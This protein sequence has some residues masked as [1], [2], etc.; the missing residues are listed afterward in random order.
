MKLGVSRSFNSLEIVLSLFI[1]AVDRQK[2]APFQKPQIYQ[3]LVL[4]MPYYV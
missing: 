3:Q 4:T 1:R 2:V